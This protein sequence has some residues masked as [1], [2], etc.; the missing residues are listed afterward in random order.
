MKWK[1][2]WVDEVEEEWNRIQ[3]GKAGPFVV[4]V[5]VV[6]DSSIP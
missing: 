4:I 1:K 6:G 2:R 5:V 3:H